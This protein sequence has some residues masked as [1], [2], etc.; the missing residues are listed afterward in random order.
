MISFDKP[1]DNARFAVEHGGS[2]FPILSDPSSK[3][4]KAYGVVH[5]RGFFN[6]WSFYVDKDGVI[7]KIDRGVKPA[8]A[9]KDM[10]AAVREL[11]WAPA[12]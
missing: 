8:S 10:L 7:Q 9:G 1:E 2:T 12:Q 6:R 4:G 11:G 3:V 5:P